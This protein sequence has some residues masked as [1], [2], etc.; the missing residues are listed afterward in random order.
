M[1]ARTMMRATALLSLGA[2]LAAGV[3]VAAAE[4]NREE[5]ET[6]TTVAAALA[7][8]A[9]VGS[10]LEMHINNDGSVLAR[11]AKITSI[12]GSTIG[13]TQSWG[14][15][16]VNWTVNTASSTQLMRRYDGASSLAE[17]A[18]GDYISFSGPL[19]GATSQA[20]VNATLVKDYSI[21]AGSHATFSG[22]VSSVVASTTSFMLGTKSNG[23]VTVNTSPS[24]VIKQGSATAT[25]SAI[26]AGQTV[27]AEGVWNNRTNTLSAQTIV[28]SGQTPTP[29][30]LERRIF[31]GKFGTLAS[32][33][34]P[35]TFSY[36]VGQTAYT[37][38]VAA[39]TTL[40]SN[41]WNL[42]TLGQMHQGDTVR[43]W[44]AVEANNLST[45]DAYVIRDVN[46][47]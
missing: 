5:H 15:Y 39:H 16:N 3:S 43:I 30:V 26:T 12:N 10:T 29:P 21:Q 6:N 34:A 20:T 37:V 25:F 35:T 2:M 42:I 8:P 36:T 24:T 23:T 27:R 31:E 28:I 13:A 22:T 9:T 32:T 46:V 4:N 7:E 44:G 41:G 40:L 17:F 1:I 11:G 18:V 38:N 14:T 33:T 47:K 45:L 19:N